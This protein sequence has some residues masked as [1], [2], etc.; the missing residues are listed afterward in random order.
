M[1]HPIQYFSKSYK[2]ARSKFL[3]AAGTV[4]AELTEYCHELSGPEGESLAVDLCWLGRRDASKLLVVLS[5]THGLEGYAGSGCQLGFLSN[6][7]D[8]RLPEDTAIVMLHAMNPWGMAHL[9]RCT[10]DNVDLNRNFMD[11]SCALPQNA[12]YAEVHDALCPPALTGPQRDAADAA[13][14]QY[15]QERGEHTYNLAV[16]SGQYSHPDGLMYGGQK[17]CWSRRQ[18]ERILVDITADKVDVCLIDLH[19]ALGPYHYGTPI[20]FHTTDSAALARARRWFGESLMAP[21]DKPSGDDEEEVAQISGTLIQCA[22]SLVSGNLTAIALEFGTY[23]EERVLP[24]FRDE[25]FIWQHGMD[26]GDIAS[27]VRE[28][29]LWYF[30]PRNEEWTEMVWFRF[31]QVMRQALGGLSSGRP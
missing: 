9:R 23:A 27:R 29:L 2:D 14:K 12:A 21:L 17:S 6:A 28:K 8:L 10:E 31:D 7:G 30:Y 11:W 19:T 26:D 24:T 18:A 3:E 4:G 20:S 5:G 16:Y 1:T 22:E 15:S 25:H 13:L